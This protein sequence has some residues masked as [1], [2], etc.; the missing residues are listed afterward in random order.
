[1]NRRLIAS[2]ILPAL[3]L[4]AAAATFEFTG[5]ARADNGDTL[6]QEI[7]AVDGT[8][9]QGTFEPR[10]HSV[11]YRKPAADEP[12]ATKTLEYPNSALR[13]VVTFVQPDFNERM[14]IRY[15]ST[16][17]LTIDWQTPS[18]DTESFEV[19]LEENLVVDAGFDHFVR[20][21]WKAVQAGES[22]EFRFLGPTRGEH[23]GFVLEPAS[24]DRIDADNVVQIRPT[25]LV[26]RMLVDPIMLGYNDRGALTDYLGLTNIRRNADENY[27]AHIQYQVDQYPDCELTP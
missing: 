22:V 7:H 27:T 18:G 15:P 6:Y 21:N 11:E 19:P 3:S 17:E 4:P 1:M 2:L 26:L 20:L 12:F 8:C 9:E 23:Y 16:G 24:S 14:E 10:S 13:P 25:S 5:T